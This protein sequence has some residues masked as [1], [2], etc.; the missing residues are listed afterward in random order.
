MSDVSN[1]KPKN[2]TKLSNFVKFPTLEQDISLFWKEKNIFKK[3]LE[4]REGAE[5][6]SFMDGPPFVSGTP[7]YASL[8]PTIA[9]DVIPRYQTMKGK[10]VR[11]VAGWD[12]HGL[13]IEEQVSAKFGLKSSFEIEEFGIEKYIKECRSYIQNT[14]NTWGEYIEKTGR[15]VDLENAYYTMNPEFNESVLWFFKKAW[16]QDLIYKGKRVSLYSLDNQTPV[17]DFEI[18]MDPSNYKDTKDIAIYVTFPILQGTKDLIGAN[19]I[20]WTTTPWTIP[21]HMCMAYN[22]KID[23]VLVEQ[24]GYNKRFIIARSRILDVFKTTEEF[25]GEGAG[26]LINVIRSVGKDDLES[27]EYEAVYS[28]QKDLGLVNKKHYKLYEGD[29][30]TDTDGTGIVHIAGMYGKED[31]DLCKANE[32]ELFESISADGKMLFGNDL[33]EYKTKGLP[34]RHALKNIV[35]EIESFGKLFSSSE[36]VHRLPYYRGETPLVYMAQDSYFISVEKL[37]PRMI[38]LNSSVNWYPKHFG[39]GRFLDVITNAPDWCISRNRFWATIMPL[40][41]SED[42]SEIV[43]GSIEEMSLYCNEILKIDD[44]WT[45]RGEKLF[46]HRDFCDKIILNKDGKEYKRVK[47]VLDC[48]LDSGSVPFAEFSYPFKTNEAPNPADYI[49]EYTGQLRAWFNILLRVSVV[50]FDKPAFKNAIV[51]G[52]MAGSDGRKMSKSLKNFPDPLD[53]LNNI[54]GEALRLYLMGSSIMSGEDISWSDEILSDQVKN[55]LIPFWNTFTYFTIYAN[56]NGH[57]PKN[58]NFVEGTILDKWLE[59]RTKKAVLEFSQALDI[60]NMPDAVKTIRPIIDDISTWYI[61][62]SRDRFANGDVVA[63]QNLY[64]SICLLIKAFAPQMPFLTERIYQEIVNGVLEQ[65]KESVHLEDYPVC[66]ELTEQDFI[67]LKDMDKLRGLCSIGLS[68]R[69]ENK[70]A[71]RQ[72]LSTLYTDLKDEDLREILRSELNTKSVEFC[73]FQEIKSKNNLVI[74]G[75]EDEYVALNITLNQELIEEGQLA[76]L[77]RKLQNA[78]KNAGLIMGQKAKLVIFAKELDLVVDFIKK[79]NIDICSTICL[80][81]IELNSSD[82]I[83]KNEKIDKIKFLNSEF[84]IEFS[85]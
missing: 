64:A 1:F 38:E 37:K 68:L 56:A 65:A 26:F 17:S 62:R 42:G 33:G 49:I 63:I 21:A 35:K 10:Y 32:I 24:Q 23:Y 80:D 15:W 25:V 47:E 70:L 55:I 44:I 14:T 84:S 76:D 27:V 28:Y 13:P 79:F 5:K 4:N 45:F 3:T 61:R 71:L 9:K 78:R 74:S 85:F 50:A 18:S 58:S 48:W 66:K 2:I 51:T 41:K 7:H 69:T 82:S 34:M 29:F 36:Y 60:F 12:C 19:M 31:N 40:W 39:D 57:I 52:V 67:L 75:K 59:I 11:R 77:N 46:L 6:F 22:P 83:D 8:L 16:E 20:I 43:I 30:V 72:P 81:K 73:S 53:T 54:G